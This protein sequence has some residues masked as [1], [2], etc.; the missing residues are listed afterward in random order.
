MAALLVPLLPVLIFLAYRPGLS[1]SFLLDDAAGNLDR[2]AALGAIGSP[3]DLFRFVVSGFA[4]PSG[5]PLA[6]ASFLLD[7]QAWPSEPEPFLF[8]NVLFHALTGVLLFALTQQLLRALGREAAQAAGG[9]IL[10][11]SLWALHPLWASTVLYVVQ[12]MAILSA[13]F[14][15]GGLALYVRGRR[16]AAD[17]SPRRGVLLMALGTGPCLGLAVLSKENG[18]LLPLLALVLEGTVLRAVP[19][20]PAVRIARRLLL[21]LPLAALAAYVTLTFDHILEGYRLR[22]FAPHERLLS[23][24]RALADYLRKL[25]LPAASWTGVYFDQFAVSRGLFDPPTTLPAVAFILAVAAIGWRVRR[26]APLAAAAILFF[27][28]GHAVESTIWPLELYFEHRNYLPAALLFL[29]IADALVSAKALRAPVRITI[30]LIL[31]MMVGGL[32][33]LR[34]ALWGEP[35]LAAQIW[36]VRAPG[37]IRAQEGAVI[38]WIRAGQPELAV[39]HVRWA[40]EQLPTR[41]DLWIWELAI[42]CGEGLPIE[43]IDRAVRA[44]REAEYFRLVA[45]AQL[46]GLAAVRGM[47]GCRTLGAQDMLRIADAFLDSPALTLP[48]AR[49]RV[50]FVKAR[51]LF[52]LGDRT[53]GRN[54]VREA[55]ELHPTLEATMAAVSLLASQGCFPTAWAM[56]ERAYRGLPELERNASPRERIYIEGRD[57]RGELDRIRRQLGEDLKTGRSCD[58]PR[59]SATQPEDGISGS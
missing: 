56:L 59:P 28:A 39:E 25:L 1:G 55:I 34:A 36:A 47:A 49:Q 23:E 40:Q 26:R 37:S 21:G 29:P 43:N 3:A 18:I 52:E 32:A 22:E 14:V 17:G 38:A 24:A 27:F 19:A 46:E 57:F 11:T 15:L 35:M 53:S 2:L 12:R 31:V 45:V 58:A 10:A 48:A 50:L 4:G 33:H 20:P 9:A 13:L 41:A 42:R 54:A 8:R 30:A 6:L 16:V 7:D 44:V 51:T 5:R